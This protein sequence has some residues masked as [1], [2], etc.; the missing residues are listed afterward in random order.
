MAVAPQAPQ[1]P[2][3][4]RLQWFLFFSPTLRRTTSILHIPPLL[5]IVHTLIM[6]QRPSSCSL[7]SI[8]NF[9]IQQSSY[10]VLRLSPLHRMH[11]SAHLRHRLSFFPITLCLHF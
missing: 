1:V 6:V 8:N 7:Y 10:E 4:G 5:N 9:S 3:T 2:P 11:P